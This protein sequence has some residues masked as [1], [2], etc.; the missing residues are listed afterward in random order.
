MKVC[1]AELPNKNAVD[2]SGL[3]AALSDREARKI[4]HKEFMALIMSWTFHNV[5]NGGGFMPD[6]LPIK[7]RNVKE[8][9]ALSAEDRK[10][11]HP[12]VKSKYKEDKEKWLDEYHRKRLENR[13]N[14]SWIKKLV[15]YYEDRGDKEKVQQLKERKEHY[16]EGF[17]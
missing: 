7:P 10:L 6:F 2:I 5:F 16:E 17:I 3:R 15:S 1:L 12:A 11:A 8:Y 13:T 14:Y 9:E 4:S